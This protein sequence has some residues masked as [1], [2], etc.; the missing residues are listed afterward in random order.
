M[1]DTT[2]TTYSLT[3]P[4]VG[5]SEDTW[6]TKINTNLDSIDDL[7]DGTTPVTGIDIN[8]GTIDNAVIGGSTAAAITGTTGQFNTSL[9]VTGTTTITTA[10]NSTNLSLV[11]TD[12]DASV[13]PVLDLYRNSAS[14]ADNDVTGRIIF[15]AENDADE[16]IEYQRIITYMPDVSDGSEDGAF[17][18][19]IMKD[20][21]R[22]QRLEH[23][24]TES[25]FNQDSADVDFRVESNGNAN[26]LF[27]DGGNDAVGIGTSSPSSYDGEADN[28][29]VASSDHTG[30]TIAS[31]GTDKRTNLYF[32]DGTSGSAAYRGGFSYDHSND[33]LLTRTGGAERMRID[34]S[35]VVN[36]GTASGTQPSYFN[37]FL[38]VQNNG[39]TGSHA[40]ITITS[41]SGGYAGLHFGD[42]DNGR[43]GQV[44]YNNSDNSLLFTA[45]NSE[46]VRIVNNGDVGIGVSTV[47]NPG[48][49]R[50]L[51]VHGSGNGGGLQLTDNTSGSGNN[52]G[53]SIA[54]YQGNSYFINREN[55]FMAFSTNDTE[56]LRIDSSGNA[57]FTKSSGAYLQL[58]DASA[59]RG[60]INVTTSDGLVFTTGSSFTERMRLTST[61]LGIGTSSPSSKLEIVGTGFTDST[62]RLQR[63]DSGENNDAGLQFTANAG[64]NSGHGIGGIWFKNS[65]DGNSYALIRARTDD[66][67]GTSG[68]LDFITSTSSIGNTTAPSM[69]IDSSGDTTLYQNVRAGTTG[70]GNGVVDLNGRTGSFAIDYIDSGGTRRMGVVAGSGNLQNANNSYGSTSDQKLKE[71]ITDASSQWDDIKALRVRKYSMKADALNAPNQL[72]VIAQELETSG[73]SGLVYETPD[74]DSNNNDLGTT[75]KSV[76]Y[77]ILYMKAV[78][79]LQEAMDRIETLEAKV[80]ALENA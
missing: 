54:S 15:S 32:S 78:K 39:S 34:S 30:L 61:G 16:K 68:R 80:T 63:T 53:L 5:A 47:G 72:G 58:K 74:K 21:T 22:I 51:H 44:A 71:N 12:A 70:A 67:T 13:G 76:K 4:E 28:L 1:A 75:T 48:W 17:Q 52:D 50:N 42:S 11:S 35:G 45:N 77:S 27:V 31:T 3:K 29:V 73:M 7:L 41:G 24:P 25:V 33:S 37:S 20:G 64:A 49:A 56:R 62:I 23:S 46:R 19:Y 65:L 66:S 10:D 36:V 26:M 2:T 18:H 69:R 79:A 60:A 9:S 59:V 8:S 38:N 43:I 40:S 55:A 6:G 14:P 57:I